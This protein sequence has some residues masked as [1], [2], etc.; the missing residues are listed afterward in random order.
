MKRKRRA[1][2]LGSP[3][4]F[5]GDSGEDTATTAGSD[6]GTAAC[7]ALSG[8]T[9]GVTAALAAEGTCG[10]VGGWLGG[11][12]YSAIKS[13]FS[14]SPSDCG[15]QCQIIDPETTELLVPKAAR[16]DVWN[17][18][19][20]IPAIPVNAAMQDP[21][22]QRTAQSY[23]YLL[24][25]TQLYVNAPPIDVAA[26]MPGAADK[27]ACIDQIDAMVVGPDA[28]AWLDTG[29][30]TWRA[31][32]ARNA[33]VSAVILNGPFV[34]ASIRGNGRA[35]LE[36][37]GANAQQIIAS[38]PATET[39]DAFPSWSSWSTTKKV[40]VVGVGAAAAYGALAYFKIVPKPTW[41]RHL[42]R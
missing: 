25:A 31:G 16:T 4:S 8:S 26:A 23:L 3:S 18:V 39:T 20:Q 10:A 22:L 17:M 1:F 38:F 40:V 27:Q 32:S 19:S 11:H 29:D 36:T 24:I 7:V 21:T 35:V 12:A 2:G 34:D 6:G 28:Q 5:F 41:L 37:V 33:L 15:V 13:I 14:A 9:A 42:F 30:S